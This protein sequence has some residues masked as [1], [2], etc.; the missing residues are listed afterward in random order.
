MLLLNL[1]HFSKE[2]NAWIILAVQS[3]WIKNNLWTNIMLVYKS[4]VEE[5]VSTL[6]RSASWIEKR[7]ERIILV[8]LQRCWENKVT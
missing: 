5:I 4:D 3:D 1:N 2:N 7:E 6:S 8:L